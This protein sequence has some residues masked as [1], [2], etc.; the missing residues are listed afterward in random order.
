[1]TDPEQPAGAH[2]PKPPVEAEGD[3]STEGD[4]T[5]PSADGS[6]PRA[7]PE[8]APEEPPASPVAG[9]DMD[10]DVDLPPEFMAG[11]RRWPPWYL[12][13]GANVLMLTGLLVGL[14]LWRPW[15]GD[16]ARREARPVRREPSREAPPGVT[17]SEAPVEDAFSLRLEEAAYAAGRH[18]EALAQCERLLAATRGNPR[19]E[20]LRDF[21]RLRQAQCHKWLGRM[22]E[23]HD[24]LLT[25]AESP[26]PILR[27]VALLELARLALADR[28]YLTARTQAYRAIAAFG[29]VPG[30]AALRNTCDLLAAEALT[31]KVLAFHGADDLL[32]EADLSPPDPFAPLSG[33]RE[34]RALVDSGTRLFREASAGLRTER[35]ASTGGAGPRWT[36]TSAGAPLE[37]L[38]H[39]LAG[40]SNL[41]ITWA[42]ADPPARQRAVLLAIR[43]ASDTR[44]LEV[45]CGA[46]GLVARLTGA[47]VLVHDPRAI[48]S[49]ATLQ[50]MLGAEAVSLWRRRLLEEAS[51]P[52]HSRAHFALGLLYEHQGET[53]GAMAEYNL[54]ARRHETSDLAPQATLRSAGIRIGLRDFAGARE[55]LLDLLNRHPNFPDSDVVYLRLGQ[56]T[57]EAGLH[58]KAVATFRKLY[59]WELSRASQMGAAFGAGKGYHL[60]GRHEEAVKWFTRYRTV[61]RGVEHPDRGE[62]E[63]LLAKSLLALDEA[64]AAETALRRALAAGPPHPLRAKVTLT[65]AEVLG[66]AEA[67]PEALALVARLA[68]DG[69]P[70][71]KVDQAVLL[72]GRLLRRMGLADRAMRRLKDRRTRAASTRAAIEMEIEL[73]RCFVALDRPEDARRLLEAAVAYLEPG[74]LAQAASVELAEV[75]LATGRINQAVSLARSLLAETPTEAVRRRALRTLGRAY[76]ACRDYDRAALAF[77]GKAPDPKEGEAP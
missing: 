47:K 51:A 29:A 37:E 11:L 26:S 6:P 48:R 13:I 19:D 43:D 69:A 32:P 60:L 77:S 35:S 28:Q 46:V 71:E 39:R 54:L 42:S 75:Y 15:E 53:A 67:Y 23:A 18:T 16:P 36:V 65:L 66:Q 24:G 52:H 58:E 44:V 68:G 17:P 30:T 40:A 76:L 8:G 64:A 72:E 3:P 20:L 1:M 59:Y 38:L 74:P 9:P 27:G 70:A 21:F 55:R 73:A 57:L 31:G 49:T 50:S 25:V 10:F 45:A 12:I 56:A 62:A 41:D 4:T 61:A 22:R 34:V 5:P 2:T 7:D 63:Y 14:V 33:D